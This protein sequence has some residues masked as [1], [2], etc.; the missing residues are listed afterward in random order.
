MNFYCYLFLWSVFFCKTFNCFKYTIN[1]W[2]QVK[3]I[4]KKHWTMFRDVELGI[5]HI[6]QSWL[7]YNAILTYWFLYIKLIISKLSVQLY[8]KDYICILWSVQ[9]IFFQIIHFFFHFKN[10]TDS[11]Y[12]RTQCLVSKT[13]LWWKH[14]STSTVIQM[15]TAFILVRFPLILNIKHETPPFQPMKIS[16]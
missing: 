4:Q 12:K 5:R 14:S 1:N 11:A 10:L 16:I 9:F 3:L 2:Y 13:F 6:K 7:K 15:C 8:F